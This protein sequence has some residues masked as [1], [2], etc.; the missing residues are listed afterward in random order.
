MSAKCFFKYF[1]VTLGVQ[2]G[3]IILSVW[4]YYAGILLVIYWPWLWLGDELF[5]PGDAG[6]HAMAGTAILGALLGLVAYSLLAG[7]IICHFKVRR[8]VP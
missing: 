4:F 5:G 3:L 6:G 8:R 2:V 7:V 1:A